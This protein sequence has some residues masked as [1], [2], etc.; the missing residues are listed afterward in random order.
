M[1]IKSS[2]ITDKSV[3]LKLSF[4][5]PG[6]SKKIPASNIQLISESV[7]VNPSE[8]A[9][10]TVVDLAEKAVNHGG[11][12]NR[13]KAQKTLLDSPELKAI[14][15]ADTEIRQWVDK[16]CVPWD[17]GVRLL[18]HANL[19]SVGTK[20]DEYESTVRPPL[21]A[22]FMAAYPQRRTEA[23]E[24]LGKLGIAD[25]SD[26]PS[27]SVML[28]KFYFKYSVYT[29]SLPEV[30]KQKGMYDKA[31]AKL[32]A[33]MIEASN[34]I[35]AFMRQTLYELTAHL[36]DVLTPNA[37]GKPKRLFNTAI[38]N[39]TEFLDSFPARN[40]TEDSELS[41]I[42]TNLRGMLKSDIQADILKKD[43][44]LKD[45]IK[46]QMT[47]VSAELKNLV[48]VIPGRKIRDEA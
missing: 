2:P 43:M 15:D 19:D 25:S 22:A 37:D 46:D 44:S 21:V 41:A 8:I 7:T 31:N 16:H 4:G 32:Q 18:P 24:E 3:F 11:K 35:T 30:L 17:V 42:V 13:I 29:V 23:L 48:E 26:Y 1:I 39:I 27:E 20:L 6:N 5:V 9:D 33:Q 12:S 40:I 34:E 28:S 47:A 14:Q 45:Q 36:A 38:T 10:S